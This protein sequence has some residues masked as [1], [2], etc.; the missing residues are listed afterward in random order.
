MFKIVRA[1]REWLFPAP[2]APVT[3][4]VVSPFKSFEYT[5]FHAYRNT[6]VA[7]GTVT[8]RSES[9]ALKSIYT[10]SGE[11]VQITNGGRYRVHNDVTNAVT[12]IDRADR[13]KSGDR[14]RH[15]DR[16]TEVGGIV[17]E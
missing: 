11:R 10:L 3:V 16:I 6:V 7:A 17:G 2:A 9:D 5:V 12:R 15:R 13:R 4:T 8:A 1:V 14:N